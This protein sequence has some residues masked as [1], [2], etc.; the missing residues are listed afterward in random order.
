MLFEE[1]RAV[2][3][4]RQWRVGTTAHLITATKWSINAFLFLLVILLGCLSLPFIFANIAARAFLI[5]ESFIALPN[6]PVSTYTV[7][8]WASY[9]PHI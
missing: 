3:T 2:R 1:A 8:S 9:V 6:S 5:V 7:P 4:S